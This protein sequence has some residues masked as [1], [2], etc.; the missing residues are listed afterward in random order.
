MRPDLDTDSCQMRHI[1]YVVSARHIAYVVSG[2][3]H[4]RMDDGR[5]L[6]LGAG[7]APRVR[8]GGVIVD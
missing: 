8:T 6:D 3:F 1:A 7:D 5:G 4:V 2:R